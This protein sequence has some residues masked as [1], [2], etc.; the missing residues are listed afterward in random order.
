MQGARSI[1]PV[2]LRNGLPRPVL[3]PLASGG[4]R[5]LSGSDTTLINLSDMAIP[6]LREAVE[7]GIL[8][9]VMLPPPKGGRWR[10]DK[11]MCL[12]SPVSAAS[13][14]FLATMT[15]MEA[16][17]IRARAQ[18]RLSSMPN[19]SRRVSGPSLR[20]PWDAYRLTAGEKAAARVREEDW[21]LAGRSARPRIFY[22][23]LREACLL[24]GV[25][26]WQFRATLDGD[27]WPRAL[28]EPLN[29]TAAAFLLPRKLTEAGADRDLA[30][31]GR[32]QRRT[33]QAGRLIRAAMHVTGN[34]D[35]RSVARWL[36][37]RL[38]PDPAAKP[39]AKMK[40]KLTAD[41]AREI[42]R[43]A[44]MGHL[45]REIAPRFGIAENT[46]YGIVLRR[47]WANA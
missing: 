37:E 5:Y 4:S 1:E 17:L 10:L 35:L 20:L 6:G 31:I 12:L 42:R 26:E 13:R 27:R 8:I 22:G 21:R 15:G 36:A 47:N 14:H 44:K 11:G 29:G 32:Y 2:Y 18:E 9:R 45:P 16:Q 43:L 40:R 41:D 33:W 30:A 24:A 7:A 39:P 3:V 34:Q 25:P 19:R 46:V 23:A 28:A 38:E